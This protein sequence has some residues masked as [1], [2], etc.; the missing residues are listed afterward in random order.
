M[1]EE[2]F[3]V[4]L[5]GKTWSVPHL[6]FRTIKA[7]QPA[8]F[9][10]Y[11][12]AGGPAMSGESVAR[13]SEAQLDRL[14]EATWRAVSFVDP[15]LTCGTFLEL[16]F[17]VGELIQAFPASRQRG[18]ACPGP[19]D[20]QTRRASDAGGVARRGKVDFDA[21]I[22]QVVSN[23][24]WSWDAGARSTDH[25]ALSRA[26]GRVAPQPAHS[27]ARGRRAQISGAERSATA[28]PADDRGTQSRIPE[29]R[30]LTDPTRS[31]ITWPTPMSPSISA[32][33]S[34]TLSP[35]SARRRT[36]AELFR[37]VRRDQRPSLLALD[38]FV[39]GVQRRSPEPYQDAL[40]ATRSLQQ[41]FAADSARAAAALRS[42][43][44]DAYADA[45]RAAQLANTEEMRLLADGLKQKLRSM[46]RK[47]APIRSRSSR[48]SRCRSR[49]SARNMRLSL[50]V[51][52]AGF[53]G[54]QSLAAQQR[55]DDLLID[56]TRRRDDEMAQLD[57]FGAA[58]A[59]ARVSGVR[60]SVRKRST[61]NCV[62]C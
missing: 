39:P 5:G 43:D 50:P 10:V 49:R 51:C 36:R 34:P 47:R 57:A 32:R 15:E 18:W 25:A 35:A 24:G 6:P 21:L 58:T 4:S 41:S 1:S 29:R 26:S 33:R 30:A 8:L 31:R 22:A 62:V 20:D 19:I 17:S 14:A 38:R 53:L 11:L 55:I 40:S 9:D 37:A 48:R 3:P 13:L 60:Q 61:R 7:I 27:L 23:T 12:E 28:A 44:D 59:G 54:D 52:T 45:T 46:R 42:G 16:P 56:A 2:T